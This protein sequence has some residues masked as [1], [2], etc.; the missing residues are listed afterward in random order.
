MADT[1]ISG[2]S[3]ILTTNTG[4]IVPI[5]VG[6]ITSG[7]P[8]SGIITATGDIGG[9]LPIPVGTTAQRPSSPGSGILRFNT[10]LNTLEIYNNGYWLGLAQ[11]ASST[12]TITT[13]YEYSG[14]DVSLTIPAG[15]T[16]ISVKIWGAGG[17]TVGSDTAGGGAGYTSGTRTV[18]PGQVYIVSVGGGAS[19]THIGGYNGGGSVGDN[20]YNL[21]YGSGGGGGYSGIFL[22]SKS[23]ATAIAIAGGGGGGAGNSGGLKGGAGG[24]TTGSDSAGGN[25]GNVWGASGGKGGTQTAGGAAGQG[26]SNSLYIGSQLQGGRGQPSGGYGPG[27][28]GGGGYYGGGGGYG[29]YTTVASG[30][31]GGGSGY[32]GGL[33]SNINSVQGDSPDNNTGLPGNPNDVDRNGAGQGGKGIN[34]AGS[35][36]RIIISYTYPQ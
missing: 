27:G 32:T 11:V 15:I 16:S 6:G 18:S 20:S 4:A 19:S 5:S 22:G 26:S 28:G 34:A 31:G 23:F 21:T 17:S 8:V 30:G 36:G 33:S 3:R 29:Y 13:A 14:L 24:G 35:N 12:G 10:T 2:L 25:S 1:T 9:G 7:I